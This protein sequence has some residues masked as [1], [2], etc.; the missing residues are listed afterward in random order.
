[1]RHKDTLPAIYF[2]DRYRADIDP[3]DFR[4]SAYEREKYEATLAALGRPSYAHA[5]EVGCSIGVLTAK[6]AQRCAH[7]L[8]IDASQTAI[9]VAR[10]AAPSNV[11]FE[12]RML[13]DSFPK[14]SFDLI[15]LSE[16]L[17][18]FSAADLRRLAELCCKALSADGEIVLCHWLGDTDY[19]LTGVHASEIF[20]DAVSMRAPVRRILRDE[21]FRLET[22]T[23]YRHGRVAP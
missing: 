13:P 2:E 10:L 7:L 20:A 5:L 17:Y 23:A 8:A 16:V 19:P 3:W 6:L 15:L 12:T 21:V 9:D 22:L 11:T 18:Y 14:G 1:M 4:T